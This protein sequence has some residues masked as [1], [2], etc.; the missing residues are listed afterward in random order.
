MRRTGILFTQTVLGENA[1]AAIIGYH[2]S[3][4]R[5]LDFTKDSDAI[6]K[7]FSDLKRGTSGARLYDG[8]SQAVRLLRDRPATRRRVIV[9]LAE[10]TDTG[11]DGKLGDVLRDAQLA[12]ITIYSVGLS[13][14]AAELRGPQRDEPDR[15]G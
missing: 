11:S 14:T 5:L 9:T 12:N 4:T 7:T 6:E 15:G 10:A 2:D 8:L 1:E 3:V 13:S